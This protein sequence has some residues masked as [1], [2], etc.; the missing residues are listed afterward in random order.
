MQIRDVMT[1]GVNVVDPD[2]P[3]VEAA[4]IMSKRNIGFLPVCDGDRLVGALTDRDITIRATA[5]GLDPNATPVRDVMTD[6]V[7]YCF[8]DEDIEKTADLMKQ[9][10]L[11]RV[12]V[13]NR[14]K[15]LVGIVALGDLAQQPES[16]PT[17]VLEEVSEAP[18]T[19]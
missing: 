9:N 12:L 7:T 10:R 4:S 11:R 17:E 14:K 19:K 8:D 5:K 18:P 13:V 15:R 16:D 2:A 6:E 3:I 1:R